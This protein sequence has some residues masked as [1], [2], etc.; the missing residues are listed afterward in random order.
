[1]VELL[2]K[3]IIE[4]YQ[5]VKPI[6]LKHSRDA[7]TWR[8][9]NG[10]FAVWYKKN[11]PKRGYCR[12][13]DL[14]DPDDYDY[15]TKRHRTLYWSLNYF[16]DEVK[17]E[18]IPNSL[19]DKDGN[20]LT[21]GDFGTT[22]ALSLGI[23]IDGV[24]D[25]H[26]P[27]VKEAVEKA[28]K[29][30]VGKLGKLCPKS[31][32]LLFSGGGIYVLLHHKLFECKY[33]YKNQMLLCYHLLANTFNMFIKE[34]E[35]EFFESYPECKGYVKFDAL[36]NQKR[37]FKTLFSIHKKYP[38]AVIPIDKDDI[39]IDFEKAKIPLS[40]EVI[41]SGKKW[42]TTYEKGEKEALK[43]ALEVYKD[44]MKEK[45]EAGTYD[46]VVADKPVA[47]EYFP[48][49]IKKILT[50]KKMGAGKTRTAALL[51]AFLGQCGWDRNDAFEL[52]NE[53]CK[54]I[55]VNRP[56]V[57]DD[58]F[59]KMHTPLCSTIQK[60][61]GG[62]PEMYMGEIGICEPVRMDETCN[63]CTSPFDYV[64]KKLQ[65]KRG[66]K[67]KEEEPKK[68]SFIEFDGKIA[69]EVW[70]NGVARFAVWD[71]EK[72]SYKDELIVDGVKYVPI[73]DYD[74]LKEGGVLLPTKAEEYGTVSEL[75]EEIKQ[76]IHKYLDISPSFEQWAAWYVLLSWVYDKLNTLAYLR[77]LGDTGTGKS[78]FLDTIGRLLY[79]AT[80]TTGAV[81]PAPIYHML[82][83][84]RGSLILDESDF[85]RSDEKA[86]VIKILN[87]G[88]ERWRPVMRC[89][90]DNPDVVRFYPTFSPKIL[91][92]R[93]TF[94]DVALESRC[95]THVMAQTRRDDIP[96]ILP[97]AFYEEEMRL[98]NKLLMFRF[99]MR[100]KIDAE[101]VSKIK[102][103]YI[104][105]RLRQA[106][107]TF[108]V[109]FAQDEELMKQYIDFLEATNR[110]LVEERA[111][112]IKGRIVN[113]IFCLKLAGID[114]ISASCIL[115][116]LKGYYRD[117]K[118]TERSIGHHLKALKIERKQKRI[119]DR[120]WRVIKWDN[121]LMEVLCARYITK[122]I[123]EI[124]EWLKDNIE[125]CSNV[126]N[127]AMPMGVERNFATH[128]STVTAKLEKCS[129]Y[130]F[131]TIVIA[132]ITTQEEK[133]EKIQEQRPLDFVAISDEVKR[134]LRYDWDCFKNIDRNR[135]MDFEVI[136]NRAYRELK[137]YMDVDKE[138]VKETFKELIKEEHLPI[139]IP[140]EE[141]GE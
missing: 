123:I 119:G 128:I 72:V 104:E 38:Y 35:E 137:K 91:A 7:D 127:V 79:K 39:R 32:H 77:A 26:D 117:D 125:F 132:T 70:E 134:R 10:D 99:R 65:K 19:H 100:D 12:L 74:V 34:I 15:L 45:F 122:N 108:T 20:K 120:V 103:G 59:R 105:P 13:F 49:C 61:G 18:C 140:E 14:S 16:D 73:N 11:S 133:K 139:Q 101:N 42:Y 55:G 44:Q 57:F 48:P 95:L 56:D 88:F 28:A 116:I 53:V 98:R 80:I 8:L 54:R 37:V 113:G 64:R 114:D 24:G 46:V 129:N 130:A 50:L 92:T 2:K 30:V 52:Y 84:W 136:S 68:T 31:T 111:D 78:R 33:D 36:N 29:F 97:N 76:H 71:G 90:K 96:D 138:F 112:T 69:E 60:K 66:K 81:T 1:M 40:D 5:R 86:E 121:K 106:T 85:S 22:R 63:K 6:I 43:K 131:N 47:P 124:L 135:K 67:G 82:K 115:D 83:V 102:M 94:D 41:E 3:D 25:I 141:Q 89:Q 93:K 58:W 109:L 75:V 9:G 107:R 126:A 23:D 17:K 27:A 4:H 87:S 62:F 118:S 51:A 110:E 21:I